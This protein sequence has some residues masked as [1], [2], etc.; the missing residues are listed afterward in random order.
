VSQAAKLSIQAIG[1]SGRGLSK[2]ARYLEM[3][4]LERAAESRGDD[5]RDR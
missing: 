1:L 4:R 5:E 2:L 3:R